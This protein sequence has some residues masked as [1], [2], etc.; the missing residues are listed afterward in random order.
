MGEWP[1]PS[2]G[3][4][5][6]PLRVVSAESISLSWVFQLISSP[7]GLIIALIDTYLLNEHE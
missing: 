1:L 3:D 4:Y 5:A 2:T 7:L 6:Y